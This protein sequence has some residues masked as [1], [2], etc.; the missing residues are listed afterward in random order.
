M[1]SEIRVNVGTS[2]QLYE[3]GR[4]LTFI[5]SKIRIVM[6]NHRVKKLSGVIFKTSL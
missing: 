3:K 5:L 1:T 2:E 4:G 6:Q